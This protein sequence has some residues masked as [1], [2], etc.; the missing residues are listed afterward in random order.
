MQAVPDGIFATPR[1]KPWVVVIRSL[2]VCELPQFRRH[3]LRLDTRTL[4]ERFGRGVA[5]DWLAAYCAETDLRRGAVIG[6]W[7]DGTLRG[8]GEVRPFAA[9]GEA[10]AEAALTIEP[11]FQNHG[12][13]SLLARRVALSA[14]NRG[15]GR[16]HFLT[17]AS[18]LRMLHILRRL[19]AAMRFAGSQVEAELALTPATSASLA[20][21]WLE[22]TGA[23][24]LASVL[25]GSALPMWAG[26]RW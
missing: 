23:C 21:E 12:L 19:G 11:P 26:H 9:L 8:V 1:W 7:I 18:N 3:L 20:Q 25:S 13:G 10:A 22:D 4:I 6:C 16:L 15:F 24:W 17:D 14:R 2:W 5:A